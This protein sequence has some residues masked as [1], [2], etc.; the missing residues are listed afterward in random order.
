MVPQPPT[1]GA[2]CRC[3]LSSMIPDRAESSVKRRS[4]AKQPGR[5]L[6]ERVH[7]I[8]GL[9]AG[10]EMTMSNAVRHQSGWSVGNKRSPRPLP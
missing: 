2:G 4:A 3:P 8:A 6:T 10:A 9:A 7:G 1:P 5:A